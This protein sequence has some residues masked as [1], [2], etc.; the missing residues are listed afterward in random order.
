MDAETQ[1]IFLLGLFIL[2]GWMFVVLICAS[3]QLFRDCIRKRCCC[4]NSD[5]KTPD[6]MK[7]AEARRQVTRALAERPSS[8][9]VGQATA[10]TNI[11]NEA[12]T[13]VN[14]PCR[15]NSFHYS[16]SDVEECSVASGDQFESQIA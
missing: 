5:G 9:L 4:R 11:R 7:R 8:F 13:D 15:R 6:K 3:P 10:L 1:N 16:L 12:C 14:C 2:F